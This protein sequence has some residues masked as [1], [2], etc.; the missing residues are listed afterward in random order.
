VTEVFDLNFQKWTPKLL[1]YSRFGVIIYLFQLALT[2]VSKKNG[3]SYLLA[4]TVLGSTEEADCG[5]IQ[6]VD[7]DI[8]ECKKLLEK[9]VDSIESSDSGTIDS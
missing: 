7:N 5:I 4:K 8:C 1:V 3:N 6:L 2:G 9:F